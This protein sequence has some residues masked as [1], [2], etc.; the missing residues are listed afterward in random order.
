M[1]RTH[2]SIFVIVLFIFAGT[3]CKKKSFSN[4]QDVIDQDQILSGLTV[5][6]FDILTTTIAED[7][8]ITSNPVNVILGSY[9]DPK[10]GSFEACFYSQ[11]RLAG[12]NPNLGD[13]STIAI[14]SFVLSMSYVGYYG[15]L[16]AQTFEVFELNQDLHLDSTYYSFT[17]KSVKSTN[18]VANGKGTITPNPITNAIVGKDTVSPQLRIPLDTILARKFINEATSGT[19]TFDSNT[20]F[21]A[22]FKGIKVQTN[23][24]PQSS[25]KGGIFYFDLNN[26][27]SKL[28]V[29]FR[30]AGLN[31]TLE[32]Y[33]NKEC[34]DFTHVDIQNTGKPIDQVIQDANKGNFEYY[35]QAF[36]HRAVIN[37]PGL[38]NL[39]NKIVIHRADLT[40]PVQY[41]SGYRFR[42]GFSVSAATK[43]NDTDLNY[44]NLGILGEF[45]DAKKHFKLN[46]KNYV[47]AV[48]NGNIQ[49]YGVVVAPRYFINSAER[50]VFNGK[51][52]SNKNKPKLILTYSKF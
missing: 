33:I 21:Q 18:L 7:S 40:L 22:Y 36:K 1:K 43:L 10:F 48:V 11:V 29:Y 5:D 45:D 17:N 42:P 2:L 27:A 37:I 47:Q 15:D 9:N 52:T 44:T 41:Q 20:D 12:L 50:I 38:K 31:K 4:G 51:Y 32:F 39:S 28:T 26:P 25:G 34:A 24:A 3:S 46:L 49:N 23:N 8:T 13:P 35:A 6:T 19:S 14:D 30:Q 16:G